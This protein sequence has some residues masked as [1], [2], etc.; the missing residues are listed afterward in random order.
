MP[1]D[2]QW[3]FPPKSIVKVQTKTFSDGSKG[4]AAFAISN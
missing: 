2:Q 4:M 3:S 1:D